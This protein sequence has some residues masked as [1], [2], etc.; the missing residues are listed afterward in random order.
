MGMEQRVSTNHH[1]GTIIT[2]THLKQHTTNAVA[3]VDNPIQVGCR[4]VPLLPLVDSGGIFVLIFVALHA[5]DFSCSVN[6]HVGSKKSLAV[7]L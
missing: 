2:I 4:T 6:L 7:F 1:I 5:D 3:A